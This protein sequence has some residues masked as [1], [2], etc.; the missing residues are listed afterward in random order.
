MSVKEAADLLNVSPPRI[1]RALSPRAGTLSSVGRGGLRLD[2]RDLAGLVERWGFVPRVVREVLDDRS[3]VFVLAVLVRHPLGLRSARAVARE[4]RLSAGGA[5]AA[6]GRLLHL[7]LVSF[8][9]HRVL[10]G[11]VRDV[12]L[13]R[14]RI[15]SP[16]WTRLAPVLSS[17]LLPKGAGGRR[18]SRAS[19]PARFGH[20]FWNEDVRA[21]DPR[22][23]G[24]FI[25]ERVLGSTD[26][27]A[28]AWLADAVSADD[29]LAAS[30]AR[31]TSPRTAGLARALALGGSGSS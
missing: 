2:D 21:L 27:Q 15:R 28:L 5:L 1:Y 18:P 9:H 12:Q 10:E 20:L 11:E 25:A 29:I 17:V 26:T 19:V 22:R 31:G 14:L 7:G 13:W 24:R 3:A 23:H 4:A 16:R 8:D 30:R 6:L